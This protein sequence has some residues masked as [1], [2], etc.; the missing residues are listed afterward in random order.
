MFRVTYSRSDTET[1]HCRMALLC[2]AALCPTCF[3]TCCALQ[4]YVRHVSPPAVPYSVMSDMF[5]HLLCPTALCPA[6]FTTCC[7]L[8]RYVRHVSP[9]AVPYSVVQ[10]SVTAP[11]GCA[12]RCHCATWLCSQVSLR[13]L[14]MQPSVTAP[15]GCAAKCHCATWLCSQVSLRHLVVQPGGAVTP[16]GSTVAVGALMRVAKTMSLHFAYECACD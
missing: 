12:A 8:Q 4:R 6:C 2:P 14:I 1:V 15:P 10:P 11:P 5:H 3:T 9:L 13:H 7:A 16:L